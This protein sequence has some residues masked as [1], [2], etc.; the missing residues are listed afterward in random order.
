L[1]VLAGTLE[2]EQYARRSL[3]A[4]KASSH[5]RVDE[6][7]V[8]KWLD[9]AFTETRETIAAAVGSSSRRLRN[10]ENKHASDSAVSVGAT[11][12]P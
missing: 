9:S 3:D 2:V 4:G 10:A 8:G 6:A 1:C 12:S 5:G 11:T 7:S